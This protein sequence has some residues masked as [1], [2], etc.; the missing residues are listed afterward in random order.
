M[1]LAVDDDPVIRK[2]IADYLGQ[3]DFRITAVADGDAM[4]AVLAHE[5]VDLVVLDLKLMAEGGMA[6]ARRLRDESAIRIVMLTSR[7]EE[8]DRVMEL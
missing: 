5:A 6:L 2:A 4:R 3:Y 1:F 8:A 7:R